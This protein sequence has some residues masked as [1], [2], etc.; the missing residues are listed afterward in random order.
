MICAPG[1]LR[2]ITAG[3]QLT[4]GLPNNRTLP[5]LFGLLIATMGRQDGTHIPT[6]CDAYSGGRYVLA[7]KTSTRS[8]ILYTLQLCE[9]R[10]RGACGGHLISGGMICPTFVGEVV[11]YGRWVGNRENREDLSQSPILG[12]PPAPVAPPKNLKPPA[13][14]P[15]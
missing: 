8:P 5:P 1:R 6:Q 7:G 11:L 4:G 12:L 14:T 3:L 15:I 2:S 9:S 10:G 13:G